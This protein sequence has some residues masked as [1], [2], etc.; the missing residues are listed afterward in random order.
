MCMEEK[1]EKWAAD[2]GTQIESDILG[3]TGLLCVQH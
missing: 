1:K 2:A 3:L